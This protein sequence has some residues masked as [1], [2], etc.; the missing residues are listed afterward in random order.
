MEI[1]TSL[2]DLKAQHR[3]IRNSLFLTL[4][5]LLSPNIPAFSSEA[6]SSTASYQKAVTSINALVAHSQ[7]RMGVSANDVVVDEV[8]LRRSSLN[9]IGRIPT[10]EETQVFLAN[11]EPT[12]RASLIQR[13]LDSRGY[14]SRQFTFWANL[15]R[16]KT[17][18]RRN[19]GGEAHDYSKWLKKAIQENRLYDVM[20]RQ[21]LTAEGYPWEDGATGYYLRDIGMPL[22][23]MSNTTRVFLGT[24]MV[25]AQCHDHPFDQWTQKDY[26]QMAAFRYGLKTKQSFKKSDELK[27]LM[28]Y[29][30]KNKNLPKQSKIRTIRD[31]FD[32]LRYEVHHGHRPLKFPKD[33]QYDDGE[34]GSI[35]KPKT[36]FDP[37]T[38]S[39]ASTHSK[40]LLSDFTQWVTAP[41]N[42]RFA[43][44]MANRLWKQVFGVAVMEPVDAIRD[45]TKARDSALLSYL[46]DLFIELSYDMKAYLKILYSTA[47]FESS[48]DLGEHDAKRVAERPF[49]GPMFRRMSAEEVWDSLMV[50]AIE[51]IDDRPGTEYLKQTRDQKVLTFLSENSAKEL[52]DHI[53]YLT[54]S[55]ADYLKSSQTLKREIQN[56]EN[57]FKT[58]EA[59]EQK[60]KLSRLRKSRRKEMF[61]MQT[62]MTDDSPVELQMDDPASMTRSEGS[63][64]RKKMRQKNPF[65]QQTQT[66]VWARRSQGLVRAS[67]LSSPSQPGHALQVFGQ[68]DRELIDN[69]TTAPNIQ[70]FLHL[71]NSPLV[72]NEVMV[73]A[74]FLKKAK[75]AQSHSKKIDLL[76]LSTLSRLA[77]PD[78]Q[79][80]L[81]PLF[82]DLTSKPERTLLWSLLNSQEFMFVQ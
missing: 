9:I 68:S 77:T 65:Y 26:L 36:I 32:P 27:P 16:I 76:Y 29:L 67:E 46:T 7:Q 55:E 19:S 33:Y 40:V 18:G 24:E 71:M 1:L 15:L 72:H 73:R 48:C 64:K 25:C 6:S 45:S 39:I 61:S 49:L 37:T 23:N 47:L 59:K 51:N 2:I 21:L 75:E 62:M 30:N 82:S 53:T 8:F 34:P 63:R 81:T 80:H 43:M 17:T 14:A 50:L 56:L 4:L 12:K 54:Q 10:L 35:V 3:L 70:Q 60:K 74:P 66:G 11:Q 57:E 44:V 31:L 5:C 42:P 58:K 28:H 78:E 79:Q 22:D 38:N 41:E 20:V 13:L 69:D 52:A